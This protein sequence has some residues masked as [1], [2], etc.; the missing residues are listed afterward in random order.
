[1]IP[2]AILR[3]RR[4]NADR[5]ILKISGGCVRLVAPAAGGVVGVIAAEGVVTAGVCAG[6]VA[7]LA[8]P[9]GAPD[10]P[11]G[12]LAAEGAV[13]RHLQQADFARTERKARVHE[14]RQKWNA[15]SGVEIHFLSSGASVCPRRLTPRRGFTLLNDSITPSRAAFSAFFH[16]AHS[17]FSLRAD[18]ES[19]TA[20]HNTDTRRRRPF[21]N[22]PA[23][24]RGR[25]LND[26]IVCKARGNNESCQ[27]DAGQNC[28]HGDSPFK[29]RRDFAQLA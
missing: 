18:A 14:H 23:S 9:A 27:S 3:T 11:P 12:E 1:L 5:G 26:V 28:S 19:G 16:S 13:A 4:A 20:D 21:L 10:G 15:K 8:A 29:F 17:A 24:L 7:G 2:I 25:F 6:A 22:D